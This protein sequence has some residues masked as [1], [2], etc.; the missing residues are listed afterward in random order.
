MLTPDNQRKFDDIRR[1]NNNKWNLLFC[2]YL[3][4]WRDNEYWKNTDE[5]NRFWIMRKLT[6]LANIL[7][8]IA[9]AT[10]AVMLPEVIL[11]SCIK[12]VTLSGIHL[13]TAATTTVTFSGAAMLS[14]LVPLA[15]S[16]ALMTLTYWYVAPTNPIGAMIIA[17]L[18]TTASIILLCSSLSAT[19]LISGPVGW[20]LLFVAVAISV[21][22]IA[23]TIFRDKKH[24]S[25]K[26]KD[27]GQ[28]ASLDFYTA[29]LYIL[30]FLSV[31]TVTWSIMS[32][33]TWLL[34]PT[35]TFLVIGH[36]LWAGHYKTAFTAL[37][38]NVVGA[39]LLLTLASVNPLIGLGVMFIAIAVILIGYFLAHKSTTQQSNILNT[40]E[41]DE[42]ARPVAT[43]ITSNPNS[44]PAPTVNHLMA[45]FII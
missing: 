17:G 12:H 35:L 33:A 11:P 4:L 8:T 29:V 45:G 20:T 38:C 27:P 43:H 10:P 15:I 18:N 22:I 39:I 5:V 34:L 14:L 28:E 9:V 37:T 21:M 30:L 25:H 1:K 31:V 16:L 36:L 7:P 23:Y 3:R 41:R 40:K 24:K 2:C 13:S 32:S 6:I 19:C 26:K 44:S 42:R